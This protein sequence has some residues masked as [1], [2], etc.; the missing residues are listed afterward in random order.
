MVSLNSNGTKR[1]A[2]R[3]RAAQMMKRILIHFRSQMDEALRP[4]GVTTA[5]LHILKTIRE[6]P[7]ASGAQLSRLCYM[8]PQ[9]AQSLL[10]GLERDGWIVRNK[11]RGNDRIL[12]AQL[13][14]EGEELLQTAEK[15]VKEI[16]GKLWRGVAEGSIEALNGVL[17]QCLAN[18]GPE[19]DGR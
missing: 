8:T 11:G 12:T 1:Q 19:S 9:S 7:G 5:Q 10:T 18:L 16:E 17:E 3:R 2:E 15:M 6:Q 4:H 14:A 13:T